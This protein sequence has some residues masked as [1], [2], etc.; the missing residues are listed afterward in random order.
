MTTLRRKSRL[1]IEESRVGIITSEPGL[2]RDNDEG[3]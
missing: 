2:L 1:I 3:V